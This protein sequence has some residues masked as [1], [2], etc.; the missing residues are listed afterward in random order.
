MATSKTGQTI[1]PDRLLEVLLAFRSGDFAVRMSSERDGCEQSIADALNDILALG[2]RMTREL[3]RVNALTEELQRTNAELEQ[4]AASSRYQSQ[5]L[6]NM[7]HELRTPLNSML[8][9]SKMLWDNPDRNL[10]TKQVEYAHIIHSSGNDLLTLIDDVL[11]LCKIEAGTVPL[12]VEDVMMPEIAAHCDRTMRPH[13]EQRRL[14]FDVVLDP[15]APPTIR[16]DGRRLRQVLKNLLSNAFKFTD[17]GGV[18]LTIGVAQSGWSKDERALAEASKVLRFAVEDTGV[19]IPKDKHRVI[20][21]AFQQ[22]DGTTSRRYGGTGLGLSISR[23]IA[24]MLGGEIGLE[25]EPGRGSTFTLY[26]PDRSAS[27][28][29]RRRGDTAELGRVESLPDPHDARRGSVRGR[30]VLLVDDDVRNLYALGTLLELHGLVVLRADNGRD[31][32]SMLLRVPD[33]EVVLM[34]VMMPQMDGYE[35]M[36]QIRRTEGLGQIPIIALTAQAMKGDREKCLAAG[37]SDYVSKPVDTE[38]LLARL[39]TWLLR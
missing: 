2:Q 16:T 26:L 8:I 11:D 25:S 23:E 34:D 27:A 36:R 5:F 4:R 20:F 7:S 10:S 14:R 1:D 31:G 39:R 15:L 24:R 38:H 13:A 35:T 9:L 17:D 29:L 18:T 33:I 28:G 6:A 32:I 19:G 3:E 21:E 30:K 37:A 12:D 22:A